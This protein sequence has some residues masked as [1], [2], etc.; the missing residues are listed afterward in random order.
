MNRQIWLSPQWIRYHKTDILVYSPY[1]E[2]NPQEL[3]RCDQNMAIAE[4]PQLGEVYSW[5]KIVMNFPATNL[6]IGRNELRSASTMPT[7]L[8]YFA[9]WSEDQAA[10]APYWNAFFLGV[11][12]G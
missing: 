8:S 7:T 5:E 11:Y 12:F 6:P 4:I 10:W 3:L 9:S 2:K 1:T